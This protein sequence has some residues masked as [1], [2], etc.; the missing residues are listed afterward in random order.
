VQ[1]LKLWAQASACVFADDSDA[2]QARRELILRNLCNARVISLETSRN[3][4]Y[5][6]ITQIPACSAYRPL[7]KIEIT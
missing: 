6:R 5:C 2:V 7:G 3:S 1:R 4:A